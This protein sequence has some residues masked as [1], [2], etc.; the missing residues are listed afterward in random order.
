M[1]VLAEYGVHALVDERGDSV[2][3]SPAQ[4]LR[5]T[6][7]SATPWMRPRVLARLLTAPRNASRHTGS[8][9]RRVSLREL[10]LPTLSPEEVARLDEFLAELD[11]RLAALRRQVS[12]LDQLGSAVVEGVAH[13]VLSIGDAD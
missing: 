8:T 9:V 7:T 4:V 3:L 6:Q 1:I 5:I 11:R 12:A 2:V 13:G 10:E